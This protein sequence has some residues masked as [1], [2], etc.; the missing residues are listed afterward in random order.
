MSLPA[1]RLRIDP[2]DEHVASMFTFRAPDIK[3]VMGGFAAV[4]AVVGA[5]AIILGV[6]I[7]FRAALE[8]V[9]AQLA[10]QTSEL[11]EDDIIEARFVT[12]GRQLDPNE[13]PDRIVPR[14]AT[15][16]PTPSEVPT[17]DTPQEQAEE[18]EHPEEPPPNATLD[19]ILRRADEVQQPFAEIIDE[20][21]EREG[22]PDGI[23]G[24]TEREGTEGDL[25]RGRMMMFFRRGWSV[26]T[27]LT[28]DEVRA[29]TTTV[30]VQIGGNLEIVSFEVRASSGNALFD[31][32]VLEQLTR[33]QTSGATIPPPPEE[34]A[35]DYIGQRIA[36]RFSGRDAR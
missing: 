26:P 5:L 36:V 15:A 21:R 20:E 10:Q 27:T 24:G 32:S 34:V 9:N 28:P 22:N 23:E 35:A 13:L 18:R 3:V 2:S 31:Q 30:T 1:A 8:A 14:L 17:I 12:L 29:L 6:S 33:L 25:Y 4:G 11:E 16:P 19:D 7:A